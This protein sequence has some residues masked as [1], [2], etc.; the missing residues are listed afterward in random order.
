MSGRFH[1]K[2]MSGKKTK[3]KNKIKN[4][5]FLIKNKIK[6]IHVTILKIIE[7]I[8]RLGIEKILF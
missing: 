3:T 5:I 1:Q 4:Y 8:L 2:K 7:Y 6:K